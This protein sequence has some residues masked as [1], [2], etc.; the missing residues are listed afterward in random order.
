MLEN[1]KRK[2][3]DGIFLHLILY[4]AAGK[5]RKMKIFYDIKNE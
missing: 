5:K 4:N 3:N 2:K 1:M